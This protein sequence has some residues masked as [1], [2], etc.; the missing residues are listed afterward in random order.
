[1]NKLSNCLLLVF[2][3]KMDV[4]SLLHFMTLHS[5]FYSVLCSLYVYKWRCLS[6]V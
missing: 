1:M 6:A 2:Y 5:L 4:V 3:P